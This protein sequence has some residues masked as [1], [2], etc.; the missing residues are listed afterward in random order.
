MNDFPVFACEIRGTMVRGD[1]VSRAGAAKRS[2]GRVVCFSRTGLPTYPKCQLSFQAR[3]DLGV[4]ILRVHCP[5]RCATIGC[6]HRGMP[7]IRLSL[8]DAGSQEFRTVSDGSRRCLNGSE[9]LCGWSFAPEGRL[10]IGCCDCSGMSFDWMSLNGRKL[11]ERSRNPMKND[12][13]RFARQSY[14]NFEISPSDA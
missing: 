11:Y 13:R 7:R 2:F 10:R 4:N 14:G 1:G 6:F 3:Q 8:C 5:T 9:G 12:N